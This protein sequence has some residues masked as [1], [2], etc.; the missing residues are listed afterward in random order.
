MNNL[1]RYF[2]YARVLAEFFNLDDY[3][4]NNCKQENQ[5]VKCCT[6]NWFLKDAKYLN[7]RDYHSFLKKEY[8]VL[9]KEDVDI[10]SYHSK[11]G[12]VLKPE[13]RSP[14]CLS[15]ACNDY[16]NYLRNKYYI[17]YNNDKVRK[18]LR[19]V[20]NGKSKND[21]LLVKLKGYVN[22]AKLV[23]CLTRKGL[24]KERNGKKLVRFYFPSNWEKEIIRKCDEIIEENS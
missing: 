22:K 21:K 20:L 13:H 14:I 4:I 18:G 15:F 19:R 5:R 17:N 23:K 1:S 8:P 9:I 3:C 2:E 16:K 10:C 11:K 6:D 7:S 24:L 12:C